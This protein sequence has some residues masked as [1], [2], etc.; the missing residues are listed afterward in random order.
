MSTVRQ[1]AQS[2]E[3]LAIA[4]DVRRTVANLRREIGLLPRQ[5][6]ADRVADEIMDLSSPLQS[7]TVARAAMSVPKFGID[8]LGRLVREA[9]LV[10]ADRRVWDLTPRQRSAVAGFMRSHGEAYAVRQARERVGRRV[11]AW[12]PRTLSTDRQVHARTASGWSVVRYDRS[13]KWFVEHPAG[14][15]RRVTLAVAVAEALQA[16]STVYLGRPGGRDFGVKI[17]EARRDA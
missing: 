13:R 7:T 9:G 8:R 17:R 14:G 5:E 12:G 16:G 2:R 3:A 10:T 4:N 6:A 15:R 11:A 1:Q